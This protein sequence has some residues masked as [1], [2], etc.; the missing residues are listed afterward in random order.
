MWVR[1]P[2]DEVRVPQ[3]IAEE[4][5]QVGIMPSAKL[6]PIGHKVSINGQPFVVTGHATREE[7]IGTVRAAN[8]PN[9]ER[10][11]SIPVPY[12]LRLSTD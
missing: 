1:L 5:V 11:D 8:L 2:T 3:H 10:F 6:L 4:I 7:F 12:F 9:P